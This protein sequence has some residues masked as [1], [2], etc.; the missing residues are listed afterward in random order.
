VS[1]VASVPTIED[2]DALPLARE[3]L[4]LLEAELLS[5]PGGRVGAALLVPGAALVMDYCGA[6]GDCG[7][8]FVRVDSI[9]PSS[10][11]PQPDSTPNTCGTMTAVRLQVGVLRCLPVL[12]EAGNPPT[13]IEQDEA[14]R[15]QMGDYAAIRRVVECRLGQADYLFGA[16][17]PIG[18]MGDCGGGAVMLTVRP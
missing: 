12:D 1:T 8:A 9:F 10:R 2:E 18:P 17:A 13:A 15:V 14:V 5:S 7:M 16:Y 3:V 4:A 11:F 6:P